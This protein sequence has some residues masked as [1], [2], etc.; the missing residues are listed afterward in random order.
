M[1]L[2]AILS[3]KVI[4]PKAKSGG[5]YEDDT[6]LTTQLHQTLEDFEADLAGE[7]SRDGNFLAGCRFF[8]SGLLAVQEDQTLKFLITEYHKLLFSDFYCETSN[9]FAIRF[10]FCANLWICYSFP[11]HLDVSAKETPYTM[12]TGRNEIPVSAVDMD[13]PVTAI[14]EVLENYGQTTAK[15]EAK[16]FTRNESAG[17]KGTKNTMSTVR[18]LHRS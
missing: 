13:V 17:S 4:S 1:H 16:L 15:N 2:C 7:S 8:H 14:D 6:A 12:S 3:H 5:G 11:A 18:R 9:L 10:E